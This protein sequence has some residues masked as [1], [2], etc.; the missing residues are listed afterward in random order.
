MDVKLINR[1][2]LMPK[3]IV[4][5]I[6]SIWVIRNCMISMVTHNAI[7]KNGGVHT[8]IVVSEQQLIL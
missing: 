1:T 5:K 4:L 3:S 8:K 6:K 2:N 7:L